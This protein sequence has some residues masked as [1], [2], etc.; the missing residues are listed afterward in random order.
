MGQDISRAEMEVIMNVTHD[1]MIGIGLDGKIN[2]FNRAAEKITGFKAEEVIGKNIKEVIPSTR[3]FE[4]M[5][6]GCAELNQSQL[7]GNTKIITNRVPVRDENGIIIGAVAVFRD[8]T[9]I[10]ALSEQITDVMEMRSLLEAIINS[11]QDAISVCDENGLNILVNPAYTRITG[12]KPEEVLHKPATI[13]IAEGESVHMQVLKTR[14]AVRGVP[15]KVGRFRRE[16]VVN[17]APILIGDKLKGSVGIIHD[18]SEIK[19]LS[20]ELDKVKSLIRRMTAKYTFDDIIGSCELMASAIDQAKRA[21]ETPATVLLRGESGTGK[22]LFAH[23]IHNASVRRRGPFVRVNCAAIAEPILESELFGYVEGAFTGAVKSGKKG[24]F[25]E[26]DGGTIFLDEIG[27]VNP[28]VQAKLLRVL[29][30][31]EIVRVGGT[32]PVPVDV[33]VI[34]ATN[35]NLEQ[36]VS[37]G[38]FREDLY[39]RLNVVPIFVPPLR[40]RKEDIPLLIDHLCRKYSLEYGRKVAEITPEALDVLMHYD[41]PGNVRELENIISRTIINMKYNE[42]TILPHHVPALGR[43]AGPQ[44][45]AQKA[46]QSIPVPALDGSLE[47]VL[48][49]VEKKVLQQALATAGGNKTKA[50]RMLGI[51]NRSL[52]Y[53]LERHGISMK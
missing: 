23:A 16:V 25:E 5:R 26:A 9:E 51:S 27:E 24:Y 13:D 19:R 20:D 15:M 32:K 22:E 33:R 53:K 11:T 28:S 14:K 18:I 31:K 48:A 43:A 47:E 39:Y 1:A 36:R 46:E 10:T 38:T 41:W 50:A 44:W 3:L 52:Y 45:Q 8:V 4:V 7:L 12:L 17:V 40:A 30:E 2:I 21:A 37:E 35:A 49:A 29:Q 34:A 6:T 42:T